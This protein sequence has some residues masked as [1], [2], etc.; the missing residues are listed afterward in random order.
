MGD[1]HAYK[2]T[3]GGSGSSGGGCSGGCVGW[4]VVAFLIYMFVIFA[5]KGADEKT[6]LGLIGLIA[7]LISNLLS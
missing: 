7:V 2:S 4:L 1:Y 3:S 6:L 5:T